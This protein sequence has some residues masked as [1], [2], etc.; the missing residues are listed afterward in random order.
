[1]DRKVHA[2]FGP[3]VEGEALVGNYRQA[4]PPTG[5]SL[6]LSEAKRKQSEYITKLRSLLANT[7]TLKYLR[8]RVESVILRKGL[9]TW[10]IGFA[11]ML[12]TNL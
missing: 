12:L 7:L 8:K 11:A 9:S 6:V 3:A 4:P 10:V 5:I 2:G 1:V